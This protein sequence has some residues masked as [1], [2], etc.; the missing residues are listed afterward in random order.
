MQTFLP[1]AD[2]AESAKIL[3]QK[4]LGKQRSEARQIL[5][6][7]NSGEKEGGWRAHPAVKMWKGFEL[8]LIQYSNVIIAEWVLRGFRNDML[9]IPTG[10][11]PRSIK[12]PPWF[13][14][15]PFH[16]SHRSNL[17][18]KNPGYYAQFCWPEKSDL[19]YYWPV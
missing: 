17:L 8:A 6:V 12:M 7:L 14:Y 3:D 15:E 4:R 1:I 11:P 2:F 19:P 10:I 5:K 9:L 16:A 13:G 18:R